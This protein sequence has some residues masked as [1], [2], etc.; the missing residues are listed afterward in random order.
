[1]AGYDDDD[2]VRHYAEKCWLLAA[3]TMLECAVKCQL[4][5]ICSSPLLWLKNE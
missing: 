5:F 1:M 3:E 4:V 2:M